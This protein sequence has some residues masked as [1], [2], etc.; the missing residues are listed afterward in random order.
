MHEMQMEM[1]RLKSEGSS[2]SNKIINLKREINS[3]SPL[4][5]LNDVIQQQNRLRSEEK[6]LENEWNITKS[7][8]QGIG[9]E[10]QVLG[11]IGLLVEIKSEGKYN[12]LNL[13]NIYVFF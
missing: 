8:I 3:G 7:N 4:N 11:R 9:N 6:R 10:P 12:I 13:L 1:N 2:L 5:D